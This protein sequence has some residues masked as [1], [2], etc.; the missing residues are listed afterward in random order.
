RTLHIDSPN[1]EACISV[2]DEIAHD[3]IGA[4]ERA[5]LADTYRYISA[6]LR[7]GARRPT[8][9][10]KLPLW[11]GTKWVTKRPIYALDD[12]ELAATLGTQ[13]RSATWQAPSA[14][15]PL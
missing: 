13:I 6:Q 5:V 1:V 7:G 3:S 11:T 14:L 2:L 9:P 8:A 4:K 10:Q 15:G 12:R